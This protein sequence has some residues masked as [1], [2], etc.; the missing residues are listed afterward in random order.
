MENDREI[1]VFK[2]LGKIYC[3]TVLAKQFYFYVMYFY[4]ISEIQLGTKYLSTLSRHSA[5]R[6]LQ[7]TEFPSKHKS[8]SI[9]KHDTA[10]DSRGVVGYCTS[11]VF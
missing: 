6:H 1:V 4:V 5:V 9:K 8:V 11:V 3:P 2:G 10:S 7:H